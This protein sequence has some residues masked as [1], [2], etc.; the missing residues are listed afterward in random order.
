M[1]HEL[2]GSTHAVHT[3]V[4]VDTPT[5]RRCA[6][7]TTRVEF[8]AVDQTDLEWYLATG[9]PLDRAGAYAIQGGAAQFVQ[10]VDGSPSNVIGLPMT[11][12]AD[13]LEAVGHPLASFRPRPHEEE[14]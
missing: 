9:E 3:G 1:L 14:R 8:A 2:S 11:T 7:V 13:L 5:T 6:V 12:V 10:S 4:A